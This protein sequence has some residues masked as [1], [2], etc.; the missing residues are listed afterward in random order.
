MIKITF[1]G[2]AGNVTGSRHL[3]ETDHQK[4]LLDCGLFQGRRKDTYERNLNFPFDPVS[5]NSLIVSHAHIDHIGNIPNL[6]KQGFKGDIHCTLATADLINIMLLDAAH[7]QENDIMFVNKIR[8]KHKQPPL[9]P[10]YTTADIPPVIE[11]LHGH[12]YNRLFKLNGCKALFLDAGHIL[13]AALTLLY[14]EE[15]NNKIS[16]CYTGDLGRYNMPI[17]RDPVDVTDADILIVESTYGDRLHREFKNLAERL[18]SI[19]NE[20][21]ARGGK[22]IIPTFALERTQEILY[23]LHILRQNKKIPDI[24]VY[25]DSP[26]A[27]NATDIFR[28]HPECFDQETNHLLQTTEDPFGFQHLHFT[29][30]TEESKMLNMI[31]KPIIILAG[32]G[33]AESGRILHHLKNNIGNPLNTVLIVG[34]QSE[35]TLGRKIQEKYPQVPIFGE[36]YDLNC[37]VEVMDEFSAHADRNDLLNWI[38]KGKN[39]WQK[40]FLVHGESESSESLAKALRE[41]GLKEVIVPRLGESFTISQS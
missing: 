9:E 16:I 24:P 35:N 3:I 25:V 27:T 28:L 6:V 26:L 2:A 14:I 7:I 1:A 4:I 32:S 23:T 13:G 38:T 29:R 19:I 40:V 20:T 37:Q 41:E 5:I 30:T 39:R 12:G 21:S 17:I 15:N 22:V 34:W 36:L 11:M 10:L 33:M 18:S 8:D 31:E